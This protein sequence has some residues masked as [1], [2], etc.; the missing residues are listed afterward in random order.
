MGTAKARSIRPVRQ[1][2]EGAVSAVVLLVAAVVASLSGLA[3]AYYARQAYDLEHR[4]GARTTAAFTNPASLRSGECS[5]RVERSGLQVSGSAHRV[6]DEQL[7]LL[8]QA[9]AIG[10]FYVPTGQPINVDRKD[11]WSEFTRE[12]GAKEDTGRQFSLVLVATNLDAANALARAYFRPREDGASLDS[13]PAGAYIAEQAC[14]V[15]R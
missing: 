3:A 8:I 4:Q 15:R 9:P 7:W 14:V 13:L 11:Q 2:D 1:R 10:R 6:K 12:I 5:T